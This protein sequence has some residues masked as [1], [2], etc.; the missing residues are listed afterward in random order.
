MAVSSD[1]TT[2]DGNNDTY[3]GTPKVL[4]FVFDLERR[5]NY[6]TL[7]LGGISTGLFLVIFIIALVNRRKHVSSWL[8][9]FFPAICAVDCIGIVAIDV[10][11]SM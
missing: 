10:D 6:F 4:N 5:R 7:Y 3:G 2:M 11:G 8:F 9:C 1:T